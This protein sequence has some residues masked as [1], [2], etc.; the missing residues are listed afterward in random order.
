MSRLVPTRQGTISQP[1]TPPRRTRMT[2]SGPRPLLRRLLS[3]R[4]RA[5]PDGDLLERFLARGDEAAF[6]DLVERHGPM[7]RGVAWGVLRQEQ[8]AED[9]T[10]ATFL[11][12]ARRAGSVRNRGS[13]GSWLHGV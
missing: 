6:A 8:D 12:L 9:V 3:G 5:G 11:V 1:R 10:Q 7:V 13:V 2:K 4:P